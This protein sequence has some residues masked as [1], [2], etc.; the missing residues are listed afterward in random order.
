M[1]TPVCYHYYYN[2]YDSALG[3]MSANHVCLLARCG[4]LRSWINPTYNK[5]RF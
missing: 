1:L 4:S 5:G 2:N 3:V